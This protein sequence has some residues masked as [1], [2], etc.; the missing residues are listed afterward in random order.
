MKFKNWYKRRGPR[1]IWQRGVNLLD[2][3]ALN[4]K[5]AINRIN[6]CVA[7]LAELGCAPTFPAPAILVARYPQIIC[8]LQ[9]R[10]A[11]IAVHGY[12]HINLNDL[13][14]EEAVAQLL[15]AVHTFERFGIEARGFRCPYIGCGNE[16]LSSIPAGVF[17]YSSNQTIHWDIGGKDDHAEDSEFFNTLERF[18][19]AENSTQKLCLPWIRSNM[20]EIPVCVPDDLQL[21]DGLKF[22]SQAIA[23]AWSHILHQTYLRGELFTLLFHTELASI[24]DSALETVIWRARQYQPGVWIARLRDISDWWQEKSKFSVEI[25]PISMGLNLSFTCTKRATILVRGLESIGSMPVWDGDYHYINSNT[26]EVPANPRP[27]VGL[28]ENAPERTVALLREQGYILEI[29]ESANLCGIYLDEESLTKL[30]GDVKLI[31]YIEASPNPMVRYGRWPDGAKSSLC[32]TGDLDALT[33][34][35]Y[36]YRLFI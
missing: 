10:G 31:N 21:Y 15:L 3:Y 4:P 25:N 24:C 11:E 33:L 22:D 26:L 32:L 30:N 36:L 27:F 5:S 17:E 23:Q 28:S 6:D 9:E 18:Y 14:I 12:H 13:P 2:R 1:F 20:V 19:E 29:G 16:L 7:E 34:K 8:S 35:D